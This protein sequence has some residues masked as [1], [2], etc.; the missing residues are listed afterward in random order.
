MNILIV[1]DEVAT[2]QILKKA[3]DWDS[4]GIDSV[5]TA[6]NAVQAREVLS[7]NKIDII[8]C[9]IEMPQENGLQLIQWVQGLYPQIINIILTGFADFNYARSAISL[10][11]YQFM[12]KP[13]SFEELE[14]TIK[15]AIKIIEQG[16]QLEKLRQVGSYFSNKSWAEELMAGEKVALKPEVAMV[17]DY[18]EQHYRENITRE[19]IEALVHLNRD[20]INREFKE[21]MG[22]SLMEYIQFYRIQIVKQKLLETEDSIAKIC[23]QVGYDSPPY[24][25]KIFKRW[26]GMTPIEYRERKGK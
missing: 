24:L 12:L 23:T 1:D 17:K 2:I 7:Q 10:G 5:H 15:E 20:Y 8:I 13:V 22:F 26:T 6:Y 4:I 9:D 11:V 21:E 18:M 19:D 14:N 3:I 25:S 16:R